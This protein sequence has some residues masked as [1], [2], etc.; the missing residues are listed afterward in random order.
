MRYAAMFLL[1]M[2]LGCGAGN[3]PR[4]VAVPP[5]QVP[6]AMLDRA[7]QE[8]PDVKFDAAWRLPNGNYEVRGKN[9]RG[10]IREVEFN[11]SGDV[12]EIE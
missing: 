5:D 8:L 4:N 10:K 2:T 11:P 7:K 12:V 6:P 1:S 3:G 9:K